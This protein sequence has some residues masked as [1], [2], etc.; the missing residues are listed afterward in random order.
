MMKKY[1]ETNPQ[2]TIGCMAKRNMPNNN[3]PFLLNKM[4]R[5]LI[6][7]KQFNNFTRKDTVKISM[8]N[9]VAANLKTIFKMDSKENL[10]K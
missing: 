2:L 10:K 6:L 9:H 1:M 7:S 5:S 8:F 3:M 4:L